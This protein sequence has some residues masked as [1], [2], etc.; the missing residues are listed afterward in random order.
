MIN[1]WLF[2]WDKFFNSQEYH[3]H[4][5]VPIYWILIDEKWGPGHNFYKCLNFSFRRKLSL[6][7]NSSEICSQNN[8]HQ[9]WVTASYTVLIDEKHFFW[10]H[11]SFKDCSILS[12]SI[13]F[14]ALTVIHSC[15]YELVDTFALESP[16]DTSIDEASDAVNSLQ[17]GHIT[18]HL[19]LHH[20]WFKLSVCW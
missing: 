18:W 5:N 17:P 2:S 9:N 7:P 10:P 19:S 15:M 14:Y 8:R 4:K 20:H 11:K 13:Y 16:W 12:Q 1:S 3:L 6:D